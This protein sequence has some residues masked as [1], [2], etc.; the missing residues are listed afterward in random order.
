MSIIV[1]G[2]GDIGY[3][4]A[5]SLSLEKE[6]II[7]IDKDINKTNLMFRPSKEPAVP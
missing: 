4:L 6:D 3:H 2:A 7:V 1:I 5:Q